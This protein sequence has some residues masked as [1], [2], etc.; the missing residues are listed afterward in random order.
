[1]EISMPETS[2]S[3]P[4]NKSV[5]LDWELFCLEHGIQLDW[6]LPLERAVPMAASFSS[7]SGAVRQTSVFA[8]LGLD[9]NLLNI[10]KLP[11]IFGD[12]PR[13]HHELP[14]GSLWKPPWLKCVLPINK[15]YRLG[16]LTP[17]EPP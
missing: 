17:S 13:E 7:I 6:Q 2:I 10:S 16:P 12:I 1:M 11:S 9:P 4:T 14:L 8:G 15:V 5:D 3:A